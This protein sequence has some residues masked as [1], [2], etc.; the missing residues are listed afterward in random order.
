MAYTT[1]DDPEAYFQTQLYTGNGSADH[2]ITLGAD[3]NMQPDFVWIK[4]VMP[5]IHIVFLML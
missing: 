2:A 1:I 4:I 3:T 5:Q